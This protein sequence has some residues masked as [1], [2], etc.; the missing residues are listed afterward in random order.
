MDELERE[1][2]IEFIK[3]FVEEYREK[4]NIIPDTKNKLELSCEHFG[5]GYNLLYRGLILTK[6][7][8]GAWQEISD[9]EI[10]GLVIEEI[11]KSNYA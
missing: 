10:R 1:V 8:Y 3:K 11:L 5:E 6:E 7:D 4:N 2:E 9:D